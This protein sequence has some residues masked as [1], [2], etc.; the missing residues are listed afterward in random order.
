MGVFLVEIVGVYLLVY[1]ANRV[2]TRTYMKLSAIFALSSLA[3]LM[4][5]VAS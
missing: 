2:P 4:V 3:T 5:I 1:L